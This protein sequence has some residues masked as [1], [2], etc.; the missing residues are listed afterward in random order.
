M[1]NVP[2][3]FGESGAHQHGSL[4]IFY[5]V[6]GVLGHEVNGISHRLEPGMVGFVKPGD[7]VNHQVLSDGP[8]RALVIW[9]PGGEAGRLL[10]HAGFTEQPVTE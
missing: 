6:E 2:A 1:L 8:M 5:V 10:E 9:L 4:E 7:A 3:G